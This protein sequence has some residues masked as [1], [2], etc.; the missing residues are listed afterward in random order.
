MD[1][2]TYPFPSP[3]QQRERWAEIAHHGRQ[4]TVHEQRLMHVIAGA[5]LLP[6]G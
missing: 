5:V 3:N 2:H 6:G 1:G 4:P